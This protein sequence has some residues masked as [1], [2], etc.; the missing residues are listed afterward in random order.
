MASKRTG[1]W[2]PWVMAVHALATVALGI[3]VVGGHGGHDGACPAP[4]PS[5]TAT[6][7]ASGAGSDAGLS[8][9][10]MF[11]VGT[12]DPSTGRPVQ[13]PDAAR[14][15]LDALVMDAT[16][17]FTAW[18]AHGGWRDAQGHAMTESTRVYSVVGLDDASA[19]RLAETLRKAMRQTSVLVE[20]ARV[21][22]EFV[23]AG[24]GAMSP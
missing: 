15:T 10:H 9:R 6:P 22:A 16:P 17:G 23:E 19:R 4:S 12:L 8:T 13:S 3:R 18:D 2:M 21:D 5:A 11:Y 7:S 14:A 1:R 20:R 24:E